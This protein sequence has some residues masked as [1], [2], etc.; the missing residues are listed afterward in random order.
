MEQSHRNRLGTQESKQPHI[1]FAASQIQARPPAQGITVTEDGSKT[2]GSNGE[3]AT[4]NAFQQGGT[5]DCKDVWENLEKLLG[6]SEVFWRSSLVA[7]FAFAS[8][9]L[10]SSA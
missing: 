5:F 8:L 4:V 1:R 10:Y 9:A 3:F 6:G 2:A 7:I